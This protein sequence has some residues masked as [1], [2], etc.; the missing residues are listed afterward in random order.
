MKT[1]LV[2]RHQG[3]IEWAKNSNLHIDEYKEHL[4]IEDVECGDTVIGN[5][6]MAMAADLCAMGI[7]YCSITIPFNLSERGTE[8]SCKTV[9]ERQCKIEEFY[10]K[11]V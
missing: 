11:R 6:P 4:Y 3:T 1:I 10:V 5:I 9:T 2:S 7:K 8:L